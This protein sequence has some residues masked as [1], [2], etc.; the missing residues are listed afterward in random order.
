MTD[1]EQ[2]KNREFFISVAHEYIKRPG[3]SE[4]LAYLNQKTDFFWAPASLNA[5]LSEPGG[6]C[7]HSINVLET[8]LRIYKSVLQPYAC[9]GASSENEGLTEES[10]AVVALFHDIC[11]CNTFR[12]TEKRRKNE[13]GQWESYQGYELVDRFPFGQGEKSCIIVSHLLH[14]TRDEMLAIR[15]NKG[16]F[17]VGENGSA[18]RRAFYDAA[19]MTPLVSLLQAA[20]LLCAQCIE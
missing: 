10:I 6:L 2:H 12:Q 19:R 18:S 1:V 14:L 9:L 7:Q 11:K 4:L 5:H 15:W 3:V 20:N 16:M 17:D 8:A 13:K